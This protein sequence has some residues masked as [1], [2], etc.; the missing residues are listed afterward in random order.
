MKLQHHASLWALNALLFLA[1]CSTPHR[2]A[3]V[4]GNRIENLTIGFKGYHSRIPEGYVFVSE[5]DTAATKGKDVV[6]AARNFRF[7]HGNVDASVDLVDTLPLV[8][9]KAKRL[10][11][12]QAATFATPGLMVVPNLARDQ[13]F[14]SQAHQSWKPGSSGLWIEARFASAQ[15]YIFV[16]QA[17]WPNPAHGSHGIAIALLLGHLNEAIVI[18]GEAVDVDPSGIRSDVVKMADSTVIH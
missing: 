13:Q 17:P 2:S 18:F 12:F 15:G 8:N 7:T 5:S 4:S 16:G 10:I 11:G 14:L 9:E 3:T 6:Q 1:S